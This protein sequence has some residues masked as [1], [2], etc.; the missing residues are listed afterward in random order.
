MDVHEGDSEFGYR[1]ISD[2]AS[3]HKDSPRRRNGYTESADCSGSTAESA[4]ADAGPSGRRRWKQL[5]CACRTIWF[6]SMLQVVQFCDAR[7]ETGRLDAALSD[8]WTAAA[9]RR[10]GR[11]TCRK[12]QYK[13]L[14]ERSRRSFWAGAHSLSDRRRPRPRRQALRSTSPHPLCRRR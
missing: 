12:V 13:D 4:A 10:Q 1:R 3:P 6:G 14:L 5:T 9:K 7:H 8:H 11:H 2:K